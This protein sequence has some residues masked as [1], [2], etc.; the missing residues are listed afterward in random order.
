M[1]ITDVMKAFSSE[2]RIE[3]LDA[4]Y[5]GESTDSIKKQIP[6]STYSFTMNFLKDVGYVEEKRGS[7]VLTDRG[8]AYLIL[9]EHFKENLDMLL[10]LHDVFPDHS[11]QFPDP[12]YTRLHE[13]QEFRIVTSEPSNIMK[14]QQVFLDHIR[15]SNC[16]M[17]ISPFLFPYYVDFFSRMAERSGAIRLVVTPEVYTGISSSEAL[18]RENVQMYIIDDT[19]PIAA[20]V[21]DQF[22][23]IGFFYR[24]GSYDFTRDLIAT[25][26]EAKKFGRDL[27]EHYIGRAHAVPAP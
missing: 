13:L 12:F 18:K 20:A 16:V 26:P 25:S 3:L 24:S 7:A 1:M 10:R 9:F 4:L 5:N 11:I 21:T 19:P 2:R 8:R 14:P 23:S 17:G 22:V 6:P 15:Q 27:I